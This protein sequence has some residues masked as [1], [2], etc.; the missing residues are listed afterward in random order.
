[1]SD[2]PRDFDP[3]YTIECQEC[4]RPGLAWQDGALKWMKDSKGRR[5]CPDCAE[6]YAP[7][8]GDHGPLSEESGGGL[9]SEPNRSHHETTD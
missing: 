8:L 2:D 4:E 5:V 3:D 6:D 9:S 7:G 1:M